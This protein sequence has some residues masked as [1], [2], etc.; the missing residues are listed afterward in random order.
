MLLKEDEKTKAEGFNW[1][2]GC[3]SNMKGRES[4]EINNTEG[5]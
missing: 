5:T 1:E 2:E 3:E 4:G